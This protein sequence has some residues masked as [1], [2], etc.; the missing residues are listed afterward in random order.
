MEIR[1]LSERGI[2]RVSGSEK[3]I[4]ALK[5][6]FL[7]DEHLPDLSNVDMHNICG[8]I[9]VFLRG[10]REPLIPTQKWAVFSSAVV[11]FDGDYL[12]GNILKNLQTEIN[13]LPKA[14]RDT[15]AFLVLHLQ[16]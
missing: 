9:K 14:N 15:L 2:Y 10:L 6:R 8:C 3:E 16:R 13:Q 1:G 12:D 11:D 7:H 4:K 5:E